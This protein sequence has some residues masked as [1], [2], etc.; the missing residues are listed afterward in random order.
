MSLIHCHFLRFSIKRELSEEEIDSI[1]QQFFGFGYRNLSPLAK[2]RYGYGTG[3][4]YGN[5]ANVY[6]DGHG[7]NKGTTCFDLPGDAL[8]TLNVDLLELLLFIRQQGGNVCRFDIAADDVDHVLPFDEIVRLSQGETFK[9]RVVTKLCRDRV[10][11]KGTTLPEIS[12]QPRRVQYGSEKSDNYL[13]FYDKMYC[14]GV[15]YPYMRVELRLTQRQ[16]TKALLDALTTPGVDF[17]QHLAGVIRG[18]LDFKET[19][20]LNKQRAATMPWWL[21]FLS[22]ATA[23]KLRRAPRKRSDNPFISIEELRIEKYRRRIDKHVDAL[24]ARNDT[25]ALQRIGEKISNV[26]EF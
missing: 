5:V 1:C 23:Q 19:N 9:R 2:S 26:Y 20:D 7:F 14:S 18:K 24:R 4:T 25:E 10:K 15:E 16:D 12:V 11:G 17:A 13:I 22:G 6:A 21:E 3:L 8:K